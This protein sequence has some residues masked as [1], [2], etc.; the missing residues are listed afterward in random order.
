MDSRSA[1]S[2]SARGAALIPDRQIG[3]PCLAIITKNQRASAGLSDDQP[4]C[5]DFFVDVRTPQARKLNKFSDREGQFIAVVLHARVSTGIRL[6]AVERHKNDSC[7]N[8]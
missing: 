7:G 3:K 6:L 4:T 5:L 2:G 8:I 1:M